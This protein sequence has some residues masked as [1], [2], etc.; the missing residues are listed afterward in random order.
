MRD[1]LSPFAEGLKPAITYFGYRGAAWLA[2][3]LPIK[4]GN[5]IAKTGA[6]IAHRLVPELCR[7]PTS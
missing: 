5:A 6:D 3:T 2:E 7:Y 4:V 1:P